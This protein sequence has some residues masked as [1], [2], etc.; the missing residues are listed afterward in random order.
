MEESI[1]ANKVKLQEKKKERDFLVESLRRLRNENQ[2]T[3]DLLNKAQEL[4]ESERL[5]Q[6]AAS[7]GILSWLS[8][9]ASSS[10]QEPSN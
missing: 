9:W 6:E 1:A 4:T 5:K 10:K 8:G 2:T 7:A 3:R